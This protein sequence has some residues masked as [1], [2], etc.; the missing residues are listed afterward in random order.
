MPAGSAAIALRATIRR[1]CNGF[2]PV[3]EEVADAAVRVAGRDQMEDAQE[4]Q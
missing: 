2:D 3:V 4:H 1:T